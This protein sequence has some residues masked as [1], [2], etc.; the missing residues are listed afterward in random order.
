MDP[1][2]L[3]PIPDVRLICVKKSQPPVDRNAK[4]LRAFA[5]MFV[6]L[7]KPW[8]I[9]ENMVN[10]VRVGDF[11]ERFFRKECPDKLAKRRVKPIVVI[12]IEETARLEIV[13]KGLDLLGTKPDRSVPCN[14][15]EWK[16][17]E[18]LV[19]NANDLLLGVSLDPR[20][21]LELP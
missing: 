17:P 2:V 10:R 12:G 5:V 16:C 20:P 3:E 14:I 1:G 11:F 19:H 18:I 13:A 7:W 15:E 4:P 9:V 8:E 21:P 6:D